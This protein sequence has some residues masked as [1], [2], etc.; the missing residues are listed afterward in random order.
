ML[1]LRSA[2]QSSE[3]WNQGGADQGNAASCHKLLDSLGLRTGVVVTV[4]FEK[5]D[6]SPDAE[7]C[8]KRDDEGLE[9]RNRL[10]KKC[11]K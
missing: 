5:V 6:A 8:T 4:T 10:L 1:Y 7:A 3:D 9:N 11:H 2:E